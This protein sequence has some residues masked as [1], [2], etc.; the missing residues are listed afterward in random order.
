MISYPEHTP[1]MY[2]PNPSVS[3][4]V[5][6]VVVQNCG[7]GVAAVLVYDYDGN[8]SFGV[9]IKENCY[10]A[11]DPR[12]R[13]FSV[14]FWEDG[15]G[16]YRLAPIAIDLEKRLQAI[17]SSLGVKT[18]SEPQEPRRGPGRPRKP[19]TE[20]AAVERDDTDTDEV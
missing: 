15:A 19:V 11:D 9:A 17:E 18:D 12:V 2:K 1:V 16:V 6:G 20:V 5:P 8:G 10:H 14:E 13:K 3:T 4:E 7:G